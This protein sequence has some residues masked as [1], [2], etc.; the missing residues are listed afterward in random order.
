MPTGAFAALA[1]LAALQSPAKPEEE[2][3]GIVSAFLSKE[4]VTDWQGVEKLPGVT[5]PRCRR[6][7]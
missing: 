4:F 2:F 6:S 7:S 5:G 1:L 3:A